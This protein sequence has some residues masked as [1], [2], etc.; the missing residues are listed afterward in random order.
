MKVTI[1]AIIII[2]RHDSNYQG[3]CSAINA[4]IANIDY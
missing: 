2:E 1:R 3:I 4:F